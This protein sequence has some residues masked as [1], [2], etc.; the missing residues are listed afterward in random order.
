MNVRSLHEFLYNDLYSFSCSQENAV[1]LHETSRKGL[2]GNVKRLL[3]AKADVN[4][5]S[6]VS[7]VK[8]PAYSKP[9]S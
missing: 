6:E 8:L 3:E 5:L 1:S 2:L 9:T 4:Q 7:K